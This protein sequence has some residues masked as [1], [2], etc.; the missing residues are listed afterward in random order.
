M[1]FEMKVL[2]FSEILYDVFENIA[3]IGGALQ[4]F[5]AHASNSALTDT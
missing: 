5:A 3:E 1:K 4:N 2:V